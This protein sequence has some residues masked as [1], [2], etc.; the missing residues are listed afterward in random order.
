MPG[1]FGDWSLQEFTDAQLATAFG[2]ATADPD[3]DGVANLAEFAIVDEPLLA[4]GSTLALQ[5]LPSP[6]GT[7][8]FTF[9]ER[10]N[11][12]DVTRRFE[13]SAQPDELGGGYAIQSGHREQPAGCI[14]ARCGVPR[15]GRSRLFSA[16]VFPSIRALNEL[17]TLLTTGNT[18][19][20]RVMRGWRL[21]CARNAIQK[22]G[23]C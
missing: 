21:G 2:T 16:K 8:A 23:S 10:N 3:Q 5:L 18:R 14:C 13:S 12:G 6:S 17:M 19:P 11:L 4:D 9:R 22:L 7:F 15:A 1:T 20:M